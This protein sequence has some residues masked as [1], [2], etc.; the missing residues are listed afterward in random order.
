MQFGTYGHLEEHDPLFGGIEPFEV[1]RA[2]IK[3]DFGALRLATAL[4][5]AIE[6][7]DAKKRRKISSPLAISI[8]AAIERGDF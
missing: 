6:E 7:D 1:C 5:V 2:A 8:R 3:H 4:V